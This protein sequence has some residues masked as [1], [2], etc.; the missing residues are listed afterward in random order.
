MRQ[1]LHCPYDP[2][3]PGVLT[4]TRDIRLAQVG[5]AIIREDIQEA[6][7]LVIASGGVQGIHL[8]GEEVRECEH[9]SMSSPLARILEH[10]SLSL[11]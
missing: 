8:S 7:S 1:M 5:H 3:R 11:G 9:A 4:F 6:V 2:P 10:L